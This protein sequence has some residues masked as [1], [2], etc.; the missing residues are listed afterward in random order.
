M[1]AILIFTGAISMIIFGNDHKK[2]FL[3]YFVIIKASALMVISL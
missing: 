2:R 1:S 3:V